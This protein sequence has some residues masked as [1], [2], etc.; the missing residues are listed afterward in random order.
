MKSFNEFLVESTRQNIF[1][2]LA[3]DIRITKNVAINWYNFS[4]FMP[5]FLITMSEKIL[6]EDKKKHFRH[7]AFE[8]LGEGSN[9]TH[10]E[11][12]RDSCTAI[13]IKCVSDNKPNSLEGLTKYINTPLVSESN[14]LGLGLGL[15]IIANENINFLFDNLILT[16][17]NKKKIL[18][19]TL[20]FKIHRENEDE[21]IRKNFSN[22]SRFCNTQEE[23]VDFHEGFH[24]G[25]N[26]WK[27]FWSEC[28]V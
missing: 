10:A 18:E 17:Q 15:E 19:D 2:N 7:I 20:F 5:F 26:F 11:L 4:K 23:I 6:S 8:E 27:G 24:F 13:K 22:F 25:L 16:D 28:Y 1:P 14:M 9:K 3:T 21:H 12:F